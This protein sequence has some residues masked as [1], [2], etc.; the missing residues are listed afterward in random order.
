MIALKTRLLVVGTVGL[1][2]ALA[3]N[4]ARGSIIL[5]RQPTDELFDPVGGVDADQGMASDAPCPSSPRDDGENP[6]TVD[7]FEGLAPPGAV[8][9]QPNSISHGSVAG[10]NVAATTSL[11]CDAPEPSLR[12]GLPGEART[13]MPTGPPFELLRPPQVGVPS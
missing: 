5:D 9:G 2:A 3:S 7:Q 11:L 13:V 6:P 8:A 12:T 4:M 1:M 10:A